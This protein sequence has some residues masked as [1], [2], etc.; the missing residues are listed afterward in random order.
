MLRPPPEQQLP[1]GARP[2]SA[3]SHG[4]STPPAPLH[5]P[6]KL[7]MG[8]AFVVKHIRNKHA[9]AVEEE[10]QRLLDEAYWDN[11]R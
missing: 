6:Q 8:R 10:R 1:R 2:R 9:H 3:A 5:T 7:F 4:P 11:F